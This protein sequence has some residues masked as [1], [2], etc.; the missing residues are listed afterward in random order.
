MAE[1][2]LDIHPHIVST[3]TER[4]PLAPIGGTR[5][6]WSK[7]RSV[8]FEQLAIA[9]DDAGVAKAAIVHSST[10]YGFNDDY[11]AD[12]IAGQSA[13]FTGVFSVDITRPDAPEKM[14]YWYSRGMTG[15]RIYVRGTT[16]KDAWIAID[17]PVIAPCWKK[18]A[19]MGI[20]MCVN[21]HARAEGI[22]QL[23]NL[24]KTYTTV[25]IIVDHLGQPDIEDGAPY[26]HARDFFGLAKY[27][28]IYLKMTPAG[29]ASASKGK[30]TPESFITKLAAEFGASRIAWGSNYPSSKGSLKEIVATL[31]EQLQP[32]SQSDREWILFRTA[33]RL[34]PALAG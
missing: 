33:E 22:T 34:Y 18:A 17:D 6:D 29:M 20:S 23:T 19:D 21:A 7:E 14:A 16:M 31:H 24:A 12:S 1:R 5:S 27:P 26:A 13:R 3:D 15:M 30:A 10:T 25:P 4:Y 11:V 32:L 2:I 28:N 8:T 9:M